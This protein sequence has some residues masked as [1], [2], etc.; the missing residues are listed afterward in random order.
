MATTIK[1]GVAA[2][3]MLLAAASV[4]FWLARNTEF[5]GYR[6]AADATRQIRLL[7]TE[8]SVE[9]ARARTDPLGD[10]DG[11]A[12]FVPAIG[13]LKD[14]VLELARDTSVMP[15]RL[16][17]D[18]YAFA[19]ALAAKEERVERF[20]SANSVIRNSVRYL[21]NA[22]TSIAQSSS[23]PVL[24]Q[25]VTTLADGLAEYAASPTDAAKGRLAAIRDRLV[26][27]QA[28]LSGEDLSALERFLAHAEILLEQPGPTE[29][30]FRQATSNDVSRLAG[31]LV[32]EFD[33]LSASL[34]RRTELFTSGIWAAAVAL[35]LV[36]VFAI[37]ARSRQAR[38]PAPARSADLPAQRPAVVPT[39]APEPAS[40]HQVA[41]NG[42]LESSEHADATE[43]L[44]MSQRIL[45]AAVSSS[46]ARA[47]RELPIGNG[48]D[49]TKDVERIADLAEQ[50]ADASTRR[51]EMCSLVD[52]GDCARRALEAAGAEDGAT[53]VCDFGEA[54]Q[55][56]AS[57]PEVCLMLEQVL[58]NALVAISDKGLGPGE[59]EI[60]VETGGDGSEATVTVIDNGVGMSTEDQEHMF[61]PFA[62]AGNNG[63]GVGLAITDHIVRKY[64]GRIAVGSHEGRG[65]ALRISLPGMAT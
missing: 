59:G 8:W 37:T 36:W 31:D 22:A 7:A 32:G 20:K 18:V 9:T 43:K 2:S 52:V 39:P 28:A 23:N 27:R 46:I 45:T 17:N 54:P 5:E 4:L 10:Y 24:V 63:A 61:E 42:A 3:A 21:P 65:T 58:D 44:L 26:E 14:V 13:R 51:D 62:G 56:F 57:Q 29:R 48:A 35:L 1:V 64:G 41:T 12:A 34:E 15:E 47:A 33:A 16:T 40:V 49:P 53:V 11:L 19:S 38:Q 25:D 50:L 30:I 60:R 55:V 6:G